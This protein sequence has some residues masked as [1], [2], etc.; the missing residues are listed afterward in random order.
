M[1][2]HSHLVH[3]LWIIQ[4][5]GRWTRYSILLVN[6]DTPS[7][8][9]VKETE[10]P[11][12]LNF[13]YFC[14]SFRSNGFQSFF[15]AFILKTLG[16]WECSCQIPTKKYESLFSWCGFLLVLQGCVL[17][18]IHHFRATSNGDLLMVLDAMGM[19]VLGCDGIWGEWWRSES[20][21]LRRE[22][23]GGLVWD[24]LLIWYAVIFFSA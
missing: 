14:K 7:M 19:R 1:L 2:D 8:S 21:G 16:N 17:I 5:H 22:R 9:H 6:L 4:D 3:G 15:R 18:V 12:N 23:R 11:K 10:S 20:F 24:D 13:C